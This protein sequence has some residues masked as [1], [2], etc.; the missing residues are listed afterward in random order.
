MPYKKEKKTLGGDIQQS[1][2]LQFNWMCEGLDEVLNELHDN[3]PF[4]Q[5]A[6]G[7]LVMRWLLHYKHYK[8]RKPR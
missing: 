8:H 7:F 4:Q 5:Y 6:Y 2:S 3:G 1:E